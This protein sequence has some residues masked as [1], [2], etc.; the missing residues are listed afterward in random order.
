MYGLFF[1]RFYVFCAVANF[2]YSQLIYIKI[3][4]LQVSYCLVLKTEF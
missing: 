2:D 1:K 3:L 4:I